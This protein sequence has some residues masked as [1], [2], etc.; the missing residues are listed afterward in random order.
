MNSGAGPKGGRDVRRAAGRA[1]G[2]VG[3]LIFDRPDHGNAM[4]ADDD[5]R[6]AR[7]LAR[8]HADPPYG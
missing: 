5:R 1:R 2:P 7:G 4:D 3:W 8:L 6:P